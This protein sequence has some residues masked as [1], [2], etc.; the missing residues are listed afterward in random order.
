M[1]DAGT[2]VRRTTLLEQQRSLRRE[3]GDLRAD[4][5]ADEVAFDADAGFADRS[6]STEERE[7]VLTTARSLRTNL[8]EVERAIAKLDDG[9]YGR[10]ER[11]GNPIGDE[12]LDAI[13][14][15]LLCIDCKK[16]V[17]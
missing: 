16:L 12:R 17:G 13:P 10:C 1:S 15:A 7:R 5:D 11:C 6:H 9:S 4:P 8:R 3:I 2:D 14:W